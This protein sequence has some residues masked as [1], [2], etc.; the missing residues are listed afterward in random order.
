MAIL[1]GRKSRDVKMGSVLMGIM[2]L[3]WLV[4]YLNIQESNNPRRFVTGILGGYGA[5]SIYLVFLREIY[6]VV[7]SR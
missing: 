6:K 5:W 4:Q 7:G 2:F 3:D 1:F